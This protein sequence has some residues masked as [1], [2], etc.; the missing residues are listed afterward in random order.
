[1]LPFIFCL[2]GLKANVSHGVVKE[3]VTW[4]KDG[5]GLF[6]KLKL[7]MHSAFALRT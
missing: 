1:L 2:D 3:G 4:E 5:I 7:E 6:A